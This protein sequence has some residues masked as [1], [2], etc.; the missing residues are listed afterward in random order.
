MSCSTN[1]CGTGGWSGPKPGDPD[2]NSILTAT[3]AFGG[4]DVNWSYPTTNPHAVAH[5]LLYRGL[6]PN[7]ES[8]I[9]I[10]VV[11]GSF[12]YDKQDNNFTHYYWIR[13]VSVNG[14]EGELIGPASAT[15]RRTIEQTIEDLTGLIDRGV[16]AQSL[17]EEIDRITLNYNELTAEI[18]NRLAGDEAMAALLG[19]VQNGL[20][21]SLAFIGA[22]SQTRKENEDA[23]ARQLNTIAAVN[24]TNAA[25]ILREQEARV[26]GDTAIINQLEQAIATIGADIAAAIQ[27]EATARVSGDQAL[28]SQVTTVQTTLNGNV[29]SGQVGL[30][31][32]IEDLNGTVSNIGAL[33]TA[34]VGVN[35]L[36]GGFGVYNDGTT[37][38]AGFDVDRFWIGRTSS[39]R[40]KP[41][42][43][44]GGIVYIDEG[45][46]NK[47][48][49]NK[50]RDTAGNFI[51]E[52]GRVKADYLN[53]LE[54]MGG[55]YTGYAWPPTN[56]GTGFYLGPNGFLMGNR[57]ANKYFQITAEGNVYSPGF[58]IVDGVLQFGGDVIGTGA[59]KNES[60]NI[61]K[62][63]RGAALSDF[64]R[65]YKG[66]T[67]PVINVGKWMPLQLD[68]SAL[69]NK[70]GAV[71]YDAYRVNL[72]AGTYF[73]ELIV[74][75]ATAGPNMAVNGSSGANAN[76]FTAIVENLVQR[77]SSTP[78]RVLSK[79]ASVRL[80]IYQSA[81]LVG[82][83][84]FTL[85]DWTMISAAAVVASDDGLDVTVQ[86]SLQGSY[87]SIGPEAGYT[88]TIL[89]IWRD[90]VN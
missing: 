38:E 54:I 70:L 55:V 53:V 63:A 12:Y 61:F 85:S 5:T 82:V 73:Y 1:V 34:K 16:L 3:S 18:A 68:T 35:G 51:V 90:S 65:V 60:V 29:A 25:A 13:I 81:T 48:T 20:A 22:E 75:V 28:A 23:F 43:I 21:E 24:Q 39:N 83:G 7:F 31:T 45:A 72:P 19:E 44:D 41:F 17:K 80:G 59:L 50:L 74:P 69:N 26:D 76:V 14:T 36:I 37:V 58:N 87:T 27:T 84:R 42:I 15:A 89:R 79:G 10:G 4:I 77:T 86:S 32:K 33:Y 46:I 57:Q 62:L 40:R 66:A 8:A 52:N 67:S 9:L 56:Q 11:A 71:D 49:F 2:N 6:T 47:L 78:Y 88:T 64:L 30:V